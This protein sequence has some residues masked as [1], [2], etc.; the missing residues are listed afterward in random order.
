[1]ERN[2]SR[3]QPQVVAAECSCRLKAAFVFSDVRLSVQLSCHSQ[4]KD[5]QSYV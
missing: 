4:D 3:R 1:M 5:Q 2:P